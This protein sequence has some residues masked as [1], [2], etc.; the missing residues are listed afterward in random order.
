MKRLAFF[1]TGPARWNK[2]GDFYGVVGNR[3]P[4]LFLINLNIPLFLKMVT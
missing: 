2:E 4:R 3:H 1:L